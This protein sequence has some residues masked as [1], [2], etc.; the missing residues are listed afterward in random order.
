MNY[1]NPVSLELTMNFDELLAC[2]ALIDLCS[3]SIV[4][5]WKHKLI[6]CNS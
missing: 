1:A 4:G 6:R 2:M 3:S 5:L